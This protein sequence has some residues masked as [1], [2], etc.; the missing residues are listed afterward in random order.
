M[1]NLILSKN[2]MLSGM[3]NTSFYTSST[4]TSWVVSGWVLLGRDGYR[5]NLS[6]WLLTLKSHIYL[7]VTFPLL[8]LFLA[9]PGGSHV[10]NLMKD[11]GRS[12]LDTARVSGFLT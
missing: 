8:I 5:H 10:S 2:T 3:C 4:T 11:H 6:L 1:T 12:I 7:H 9:V